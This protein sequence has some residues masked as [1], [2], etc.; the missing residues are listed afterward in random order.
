VYHAV[1]NF[2]VRELSSFY[3]DVLKD[4]LYTDSRASVSG[5]SCRTVLH[6]ILAVL[7][8]ILAPVLSFTCEEVWAEMGGKQSIHLE[9]WPAR[10][11]KWRDAELEARFERFSAVRDVVLKALEEKREKKRD[12]QFIRG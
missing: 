1:Y 2:C 6:E 3:L 5:R 10:S 7:V 9:L 4:R 8:R 11:G 12:W